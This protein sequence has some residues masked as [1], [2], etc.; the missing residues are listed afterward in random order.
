M[1]QNP[2]TQREVRSVCVPHLHYLRAAM[3]DDVLL[4]GI[5]D[6][7]LDQSTGLPVTTWGHQTVAGWKRRKK[8][9]KVKKDGE[10]EKGSGLKVTEDN[11]DVG[12][13]FFFLNHCD[14]QEKIPAAT[15]YE[16]VRKTNMFSLQTQIMKL[17]WP[18]V[19]K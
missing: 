18:D 8:V 13:S 14:A 15:F 6:R 10:T 11:S 7:D 19:Q 5:Y 16:H 17:R 4:A 2:M 1:N 12:L 9:K 3:A